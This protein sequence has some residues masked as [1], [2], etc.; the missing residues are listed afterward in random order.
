MAN[1][2]VEKV[3]KKELP[4]HVRQMFEVKAFNRGMKLGEDGK[5]VKMTEAEKKSPEFAEIAKRAK[6]V[7]DAWQALL[8]SHVTTPK[9]RKKS[10]TIDV[11]RLIKPNMTFAEDAMKH[12]GRQMRL[13][14][15]KIVIAEVEKA[16]KEGRTVLDFDGISLNSLA[17]GIATK[18]VRKAKKIAKLQEKIKQIED[19]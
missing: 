14:G 13:F 2:P 7:H 17:N 19:E 11:T 18:R 10:M 12:L 15:K 3:E 6:G 8:A 5:W 1:E 16:L 4:E 9:Q